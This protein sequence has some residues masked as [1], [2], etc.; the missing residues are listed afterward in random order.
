MS[1]DNE[2]VRKVAFLARLK[3]E[4]EKL[5]KRKLNLITFWNG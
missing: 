2:T 3:V 1:V 4:P 5:K